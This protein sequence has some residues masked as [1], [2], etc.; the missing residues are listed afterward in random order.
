MNKKEIFFVV[1]LYKVKLEDSQTI[2]S[3][4]EALETSTNLLVFDNS[5]HRQ[6]EKEYFD[7]GKFSIHYHHDGS[8]PGLSRAYNLAL[9]FASQNN[10]TWLLLLD[11]DTIFTVDY[12]KEIQDIQTDQ[13][14]NDVA[15]IIPKVVSNDHNK[16]ISPAILYLG[17]FAKPVFLDKGIAHLN[18]N[19]INSGTLLRVY[20]MNAIGGFNEKYPLDMLD[21]WYFSQI[22]KRKKNVYVMNSTIYQN[23]SVYGNFEDNVSVQRYEGLLQAE[24]LLNKDAGWLNFLVFKARLCFRLFKQRNYKNQQYGQLTLKYILPF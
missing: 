11:Q 3:L 10:C 20:F 2:K 9:E 24:R 13:L 19:G 21:H 5:P 12:I 6:Y 18:I 1:V 15:A 14:S 17:G 16:V 4:D 7:L 23:L 8:N 22:F